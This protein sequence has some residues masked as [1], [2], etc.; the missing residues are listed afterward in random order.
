[1]TIAQRFLL[2]DERQARTAVP[3]RGRVSFAIAR[4]NDNANLFDACGK[5]LLDDDAE[6]RLGCAIPIDQR[7]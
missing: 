7:L 3:G 5:N 1:M 6:G 4:A 2:F